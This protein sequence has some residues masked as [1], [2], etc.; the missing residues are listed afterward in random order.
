MLIIQNEKHLTLI[1]KLK[2]D[3]QLL[4][5]EVSEKYESGSKTSRKANQGVRSFCGS[6]YR[7]IDTKKAIIK[8]IEKGLN[9]DIYMA[10]DFLMEHFS[11]LTPVEKVRLAPCCIYS[12]PPFEQ[13]ILIKRL[14]EKLNSAYKKELNKSKRMGDLV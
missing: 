3:I 4:Y 2:L 12:M 1:E 13:S 11:W 7:K 14:Y 9:V 6:H 8:F 5:K 10:Q